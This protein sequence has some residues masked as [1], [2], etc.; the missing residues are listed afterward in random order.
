M[1]A[2]Q[3]EEKRIEIM[4]QKILLIDLDTC[5]RC[6]AC[7]VACREEHNLSFES[8]SRWCQVMT[9]GP[10]WVSQGLHLDFVPTMCFQCDDTPCASFCFVD[11]ISKREDGI[12]MVDEVV[13]NGCKLCVSGCPYGA[14]FFN[15]TK[16]IAGKCDFCISRIQVGLE[17]TCVQHC[18]GGALQ[19]V[20]DEELTTITSVE[21]T[22]RIGM[23]Y[24]ASSKWRLSNGI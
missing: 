10:R 6:Y 7:E 16:G 11:A 20:T 14:M 17:P 24:Y 2:V 22:L 23:I 18:I 15:E 3:G 19:F 12:V 5:V 1:P 9:V 21:H 8:Q 4:S 13:C